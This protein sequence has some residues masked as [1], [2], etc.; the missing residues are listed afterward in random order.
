MVLL[1]L[2][3]F[4]PLLVPFWK[5]LSAAGK[6]I[7]DSFA[8]ILSNIWN[9]I[10]SVASSAWEGLKSTVLGLIDGLVQGAKNAW[11]SMK[12]GVR[13]LVS[14]VTSIF[15]GIR[16]IDL[17]SAGKAILDG[18]LGGLKSALGSSN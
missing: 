11:E 9:T 8:Q 10:K 5:G 13:D 7:F 1:F 12:Q 4:L 18:F 17:W 14:N 16:N 15:D 3:T 2:K 6:A